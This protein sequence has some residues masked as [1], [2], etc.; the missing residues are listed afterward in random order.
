MLSNMGLNG[1]GVDLVGGKG[2]ERVRRKFWSNW[3]LLVMWDA[4]TCSDQVMVKWVP[5][6]CSHFS[7]S[8]NLIMLM[9]NFILFRLESWIIFVSIKCSHIF[10]IFNYYW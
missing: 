9:Y 6:K 10:L 4:K 3:K 1:E 8:R 2:G 5:K 7:L